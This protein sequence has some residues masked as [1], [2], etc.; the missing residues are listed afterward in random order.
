MIRP[1]SR[2]RDATS[3]A[4]EPENR[5][6]GNRLTGDRTSGAAT[7]ASVA[8]PSE[9]GGWSLTLEPAV[10]GLIASPS[11]AGALIGAGALVAFLA[12]T[13]AKTVMVDRSRRRSL[14]RTRLARWVLGFES[15]LLIGLASGAILTAQRGFG[16]PLLVALPLVGVELWFDARSRSRRL[17]P[18]MAGS[19]GVGSVASMIALAGGASGTVA[20][21]LWVVI[22]ARVVEAVPFVRVQLRRAKH[23]VFRL[24]YS[25][26]AQVAGLA[27]ALTGWSFGAV[28][29]TG[30]AALFALAA[31]HLAMVRFRPISTPM[32]GA[33]QVIAGLIVVLATGFGVRAA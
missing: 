16:W 29:G 32:L 23:Q 4:S 10:L 2:F 5:S 24:A 7:L 3:T 26:I 22:A 18:E 14:P 20:V 8:L 1:I 6:E 21:A 33:Q 27:I 31:Y 15:L 19:I 28:P 17:I 12:R 9:H 11:V 25:D 13:P 30:V